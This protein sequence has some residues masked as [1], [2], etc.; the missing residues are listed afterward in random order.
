MDYTS[1]PNDR[2]RARAAQMIR[3]HS[4]HIWQT[5]RQ[6]E[7]EQF[8]GSGVVC[9]VCGLIFSAFAPVYQWKRSS[10][11]ASPPGDQCVTIAEAERCPSCNSLPRHRLLWKYLETET[12]IFQSSPLRLLDIAPTL[13]FYD[14]FSTSANISY[15]PCDIDPNQQKYSGFPGPIL[16]A[17]LC[18][19]P[20][21]D[22]FFDVILC[23][24][25]LEH[26]KND[27][28]AICEM[29]RVL[30]PGGWGIIQVPENNLLEMTLEDPAIVLPEARES[31]FG[32]FDHVRQYGRDFRDRLIAGGF[33]VNTIDFVKTFPAEQI[34]SFGFDRYEQIHLCTKSILN[35]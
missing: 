5:I 2:I 12:S 22:D 10:L 17:S 1:T 9:P 27:H 14:R 19:L 4:E 31:A 24:H 30:K 26:I 35:Q 18:E 8:R 32:Q 16:R 13:P 6:R 33:Q 20:F 23:S 3:Q 25:V 7:M 29:F 11:N 34:A 15:F 21:P 28:L